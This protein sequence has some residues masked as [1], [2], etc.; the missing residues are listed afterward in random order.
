[1]I[2]H[3]L[4]GRYLILKQLGAGGFS[5]THLARDKYLPHHPLCVVKCLKLSSSST[6]TWETAQRL[7]ETEARILDQLG[8][9]HSQIPTLF[10]YCHEQDQVYQVQEYIDGENLAGWIAQKRRLTS[11][12]AIELLLEVLPVLDYIHSLRVIHRDV[13][14]SNLIRRRSD[15]KMVLIDFGAACLLPETGCNTSP[16]SD[17]MP[18]AIGTPGYMPD[19]QHL[20]MCQFNSDLYALGILVIQLLTGVQPQQFQQNLISGE[21]NWQTYL[22]EPAIDPKLIAILDQMIR[23]HP[24][25]RY[26]QAAEVLTALQALPKTGR[27]SK[28]FVSQRF[29]SQRRRA[30]QR[31]MK[32]AGVAIVL[33]GLV[34]GAGVYHSQQT[35][36]PLMGFHFLSPQP[37]I[38]LTL[39][40]DLPI[41]FGIEQLLIAPN[42]RV[43]VAAGSDHRLHLWSLA[44]GTTLKTLPGHTD[45]VIALAMSQDSRLLVSGGTDR[46][47]H[48][49]DIDSG[50]LLQTFAAQAAVTA[51]AISPAADQIVSGSQDGTISIWNRQTGALLQTLAISDAKITALAYGATPF[52]LISASHDRL[53]VWDLR[54]GQ[55]HRSF[56]GHTAPIGGLQVVDNHTLVS[57]GDDRALVWDLQREEL[58]QVCSDDSAKPVTASLNQQ[59]MIAVDAS[60]H[61]QV[62]SRKAGQLVRDGSGELGRNLNVALSPDQLYLVNW[63]SDH[64]LQIW[65]LQGEG[66]RE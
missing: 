33:A 27:A 19:E 8:Q 28:R 20:G 63:R 15:G 53:Q 22:P 54:T 1:M 36:T 37:K 4:T 32:P 55:L 64:R 57:F 44:E 42:N 59:R 21:L 56:A 18:M 49:W 31:V 51:I 13:K 26:Q 43:L 41:Q 6:I 61:I 9:N 3:L 62:W 39:L 45:R 23:S 46:T 7:F 65:Q 29:V 14:P 38:G 40:H 50:T 66:I 52:N 11:A 48:L 35:H 10:A 5:E 25:H 34:G 12:A 17:D 16:D 60:G 24:N 58:M 47:I 2:G 30:M